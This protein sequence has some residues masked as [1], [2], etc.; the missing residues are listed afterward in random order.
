MLYIDTHSHINFKKFV[1]DSGRVILNA[2]NEGI[3]MIIVGTDYKSSRKAIDLANRYEEG[4]YAAVGLHPVH[5]EDQ[6]ED[7]QGRL[8]FR[9]RA[10]DWNYEAY[11]KLAQM[12]KVVAIGEIGLDYY[13]LKITQDIFEKKQKQKKVLVEQ[14]LLARRLD[15]PVILHCRNAH[16]DMLSLLDDFRH[17]YSDLIPKDR[18]WG[19]VHCFSG[20]ENLAW[21]YF[22]MGLMISFTGII[23]FSSAWDALIRKA[24]L[25]KMMIETD[26]PFMTPE[27]H[28]GKRNEPLLVPLVA[29][30]IA[31]IRGVDVEKVALATTKNAQEFFGL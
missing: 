9:G 3:G 22:N 17:E 23:T 28:R 12:E 30:R 24:P 11:D 27:P 16:D 8:I 13:H 31:K 20:D 15:L 7:E 19:V 4:V 2:L 6:E 18:S 21:K 26:C 14:L 10:E 29:E 25:D 1:D 5:L